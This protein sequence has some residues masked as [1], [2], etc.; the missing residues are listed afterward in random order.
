LQNNLP[1]NIFSRHIFWSYNEDA[2][3][4]EEEIVRKVISYGDIEDLVKLSEVLPISRIVQL[5]KT[6]KE[7]T[8]FEKRINF[9]QK[10]IIEQ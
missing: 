4:P 10:V 6:W 5:L 9:F 8:R 1:I 3:L 2:N 7:R